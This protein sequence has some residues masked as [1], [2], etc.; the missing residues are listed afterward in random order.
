MAKYQAI[1]TTGLAVAKLLSE[2]RPRPDFDHA[3]IEL[4]QHT[5]FQAPM[6]E[7][8]SLYL[9]S[10][11]PRST[12]NSLQAGRN[13]PLLLDLHYLLTP[14]A[15]SARRQHLMLGWAMRVLCDSPIL[16]GDFLNSIEP[17]AGIFRPDEALE[18]LDES[19]GNSGGEH[20]W[21]WPGSG[22]SAHPLSVYYAVRGLA[23]D[24]GRPSSDPGPVRPRSIDP[25][26]RPV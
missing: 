12:R 14:W 25:T 6:D 13:P 3:Q 2:A 22:G 17:A 15:K 19:P 16:A 9:Y 7:G 24:S 10:A 23:I 4:Y 5:S 11:T 18:I 20:Q 26:R 8:L 21:V 1:A